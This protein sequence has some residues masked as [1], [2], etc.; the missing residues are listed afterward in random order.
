M[1]QRIL[2]SSPIRPWFA[3]RVLDRRDRIEKPVP[4][5]NVCRLDLI[6]SKPFSLLQ[7]KLKIALNQ[8]S[9]KSKTGHLPPYALDFYF[10]S[11]CESPAEKYPPRMWGRA[12]ESCRSELSEVSRYKLPCENPCQVFVWELTNRLPL[13]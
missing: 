13:L 5:G 1:P 9:A 6:P 8:S 2:V 11:H 10:A 3:R 7:S 12:V 4:S